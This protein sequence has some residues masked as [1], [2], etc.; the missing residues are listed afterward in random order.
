MKKFEYN[1]FWVDIFNATNLQE[2]LDE[3]G[4]N[5]WELISVMPS[6]DNSYQS[7]F[8]MKKEFIEE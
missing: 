7:L 8:I 2:F 1:C 5:G 4:K 3:K 6:K